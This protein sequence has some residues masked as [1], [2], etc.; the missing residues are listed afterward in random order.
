MKAG[1]AFDFLEAY[2]RWQTLFAYHRLKGWDGSE[3]KAPLE[4]RSAYA[5][6]IAT[7]EALHVDVMGEPRPNYTER[8]RKRINEEL[9]R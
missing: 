9:Q 8:A 2:N 3:Q 1:A 5:R 6:M 7:Y 4:V